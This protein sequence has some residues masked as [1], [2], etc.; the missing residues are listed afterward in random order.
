MRLYAR[1]HKGVDFVTIWRPDRIEFEEP[2][3]L[4]LWHLL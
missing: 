2:M 3:G 4:R 1:E